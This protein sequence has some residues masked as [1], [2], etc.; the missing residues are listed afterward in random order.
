MQRG[1]GRDARFEKNC[2]TAQKKNDLPNSEGSL[3]YNYRLNKNFR[4]FCPALSHFIFEFSIIHLLI[5]AASIVFSDDF[6]KF[7]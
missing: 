7:R 2:E 4:F 6:R 5:E 3:I 1:G